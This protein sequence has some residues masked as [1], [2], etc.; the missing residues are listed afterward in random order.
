M[1]KEQLKALAQLASSD[2]DIDERELRLINRIGEAH[3]LSEE[4]IQEIINSPAGQLGDLTSLSEDDK[5]EFLYSIIQLM[6]ID[7]EVYNEEVLFCQQIAMKLGYGLGAV[8][9][10]YPLVH[11]N[12]VIRSEKLQLKKRLQ[13]FLK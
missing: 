4:A 11:K 2:G 9:E 8:M 12:L 1:V 5:F 13:K 10:M 3:G 6:K 7:D